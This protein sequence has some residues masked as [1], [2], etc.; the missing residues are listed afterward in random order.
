MAICIF[1]TISQLGE[2]FVL[3]PERYN[4][5][6]RMNIEVDGVKLSELVYLSDEILTFKKG[7]AE[8]Q[9]QINTGDAMGGYLRIPQTKEMLNSSKKILHKGDVIISRLRPYL[10][11]IAY[12]DDVI[13]DGLYASTEFYVLR[14]RSEQS[15][16]FLV[17]YLLSDAAQT[18]FA[19]SVEGSQ[20][21]RFK[22]D[23]INNLVIPISLLE[24]RDE[25]SEEVESAIRDY[26]EYESR[27]S[28]QIFMVNSAMQGA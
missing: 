5:R 26:R 10:K 13:N 25:L 22:E 2:T 16:A 17:P 14:G 9:Y 12:V 18:V 23:D 27:L 4:P 8:E 1:K 21:P 11:Q 28:R 20:H 15:I 7:K 24:K 19:N 6:R 3:T